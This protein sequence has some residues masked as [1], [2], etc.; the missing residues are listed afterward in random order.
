MF[1]EA[2]IWLATIT[3]IG[4]QMSKTDIKRVRERVRER[5]RVGEREGDLEEKQ[6]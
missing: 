4:L 6:Q 2:V 3:N 1:I 5:E